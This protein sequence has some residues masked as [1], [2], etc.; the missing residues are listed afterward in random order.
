MRRS[1]LHRM[2]RQARAPRGGSSATW[3]RLAL[4]LFAL[5]GLIALQDRLGQA[6]AGC[7]ATITGQQGSTQR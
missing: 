7:F 1:S 3:M 5:V 6:G 2:V 4:L